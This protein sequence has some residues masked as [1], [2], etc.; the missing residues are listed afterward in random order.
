MHAVSS[1]S[2]EKKSDLEPTTG[3]LKN[4]DHVNNIGPYNPHQLDSKKSFTV[5]KLPCTSKE[6]TRFD[7]ITRK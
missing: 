1:S 5:K 6:Y 3:S 4:K 7:R 2:E